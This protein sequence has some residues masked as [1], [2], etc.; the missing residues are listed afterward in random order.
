[1]GCAHRMSERAGTYDGVLRMTQT[2]KKRKEDDYLASFQDVFE[3][4]VGEKFPGGEVEEWENPDFLVKRPQDCLGIEITELVRQKHPAEKY[5]AAQKAGFCQKILDHAR[6]LCEQWGVP[7]LW[8]TVWIIGSLD[9][10]QGRDAQRRL[11]EKLASLVKE[12]CDAHPE[13]RDTVLKPEDTLPEIYQ[14]VVWRLRSS[15]VHRWEWSPGGVWVSPVSVDSLQERIGRKDKKYGEYRRH[16]AECWLLIVGDPCDPAKGGDI[17]LDAAARTHK[18]QSQFD[19][20][21]FLQL[22]DVLVELDLADR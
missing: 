4:K 20:I 14:I 17:R 21:F 12:W 3:P 11:S 5:R 16:C 6:R 19:R 7:P 10:M 8:V 1:M 9:H 13:D 18:Y 22:H 15:G 2:R